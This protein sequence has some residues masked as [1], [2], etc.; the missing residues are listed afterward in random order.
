M[1][2]TSAEKDTKI[3]VL[4]SDK[5]RLEKRVATL[6]AGARQADRVIRRFMIENQKL[7]G[8]APMKLPAEEAPVA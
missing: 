5:R 8:L 4:K 7:K 2:R 3:R 1:G 6:E